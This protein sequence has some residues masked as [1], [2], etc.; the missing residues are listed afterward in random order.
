MRSTPQ[1]NF[2]FKIGTQSF[3][4]TVLTSRVAMMV[5]TLFTCQKQR[6]WVGGGRGEWGVRF[7][8]SLCCLR[9]SRLCIA[10]LDSSVTWRFGDL[11][12]HTRFKKV[13]GPRLAVVT[14]QPPIQWV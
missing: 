13:M 11:V 7:G 4:H 6:V 8:F 1:V 3:T 10:R 14:I 5:L 2:T 12:T 9:T